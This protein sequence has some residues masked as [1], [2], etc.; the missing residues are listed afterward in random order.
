MEWGTNDDHDDEEWGHPVDPDD[1]PDESPRLW[2]EAEWLP[3][4]WTHP[5]IIRPSR[6]VD[7]FRS[8]TAGMMLSGIG[9][10]LRDI[11]EGPREEAP[12]EIEA[13]GEPPF[14]RQVEIDLHPENPA[15]SVVVW[16]RR[17]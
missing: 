7:R 14:P 8:T 16:H 11:L 6:S 13:A 10:G 5:E 17:V 4:T 15:A 3:D 9:L 1:E 12:I 2:V